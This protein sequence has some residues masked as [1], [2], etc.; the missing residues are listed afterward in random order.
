MYV[1]SEQV[2]NDVKQGM[3]TPWF[4][5]NYCYVKHITRIDITIIQIIYMYSFL[6]N[7]SYNIQYHK[8]Y[9]YTYIMPNILNSVCFI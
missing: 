6:I 5:S 3:I 8:F 2:F 1:Y 4:F 7:S 9:C